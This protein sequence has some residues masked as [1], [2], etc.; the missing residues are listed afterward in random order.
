MPGPTWVILPTYDEAATLELVV[1]GLC[2]VLPGACPDGWRILVVDDG[3]PDGTG[4]IADGLAAQEPRIEVLHRA[5]K[6]GLGRAYV[7]GFTH[8][9]AGG[10]G[11]VVEMDADLSHDPRHLPALLAQAR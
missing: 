3:S 11:L 6:D 7:A 2:A 9:L 10:A 1:T 5:G 4:A 8:A